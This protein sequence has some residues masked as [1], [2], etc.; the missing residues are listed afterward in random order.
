MKL[1][2][3]IKMHFVLNYGEI[4]INNEQYLEPNASSLQIVVNVYKLL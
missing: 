2:S 4:K 1:L 3:A